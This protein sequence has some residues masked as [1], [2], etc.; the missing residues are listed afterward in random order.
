MF[1][2]LL[3]A[4]CGGGGSSPAVAERPHAV[5]ATFT[6]AGDFGARAAQFSRAVNPADPLPIRDEQL[7]AF[8][9]GAIG[10]DGTNGLDH[11]SPITVIA[12]DL[13]DGS[14]TQLALVARVEDA[15]RVQEQRGS[16]TIVTRG[17]F[18]VIAQKPV[19]DAVSA[20]AFEHLI[21]E[22]A[23]PSGFGA[24]IYVPEV[25]RIHGAHFDRFRAA[26]AKEVSGGDP[27]LERV[28]AAAGDAIRSVGD[29]AAELDITLDVVTE[30]AIDVAIVPK[31]GSALAAF[32][33]A[34]KP[35]DFP[36]ILRLPPAGA[37]PPPVIAGGRVDPG[38]Y[39]FAD[40]AAS[41]L[42]YM[43]ASDAGSLATALGTAG[44]EDVALVWRPEQTGGAGTALATM[45]DPASA[46]KAVTS[47]PDLGASIVVPAGI[48]MR[49]TASLVAAAFDRLLLITT[50]PTAG[51]RAGTAIELA[52]SRGARGDPPASLAKYI[53]R[54]RNDRDFAMAVID[55]PH[56]E[57][58]QVV[59][60]ATQFL[61]G[62]GIDKGVLHV[63][64]VFTP[65]AART[66]P[67]E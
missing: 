12:V 20:W 29:D 67:F 7:T 1:A 33:A 18:A 15:N 32:V 21:V 17:D 38:P 11:T 14:G 55:I 48:T 19:A 26:F 27:A 62:A 51:P 23:P 2:C 52:R 63:R 61:V 59:G 24:V 5:L 66:L 53:E 43:G 49:G 64:A 36:L 30:L 28:L 3:A 9:R 56:F 31:E 13:G 42:A 60:A 16:A 45:T 57:V 41:F 39:R 47:L 44:V 25:L 46:A 6:R 35:S 34:Q 4:S 37:V 65:A 50:G 58:I 22:P 40:R 54:A 8:G 10:F